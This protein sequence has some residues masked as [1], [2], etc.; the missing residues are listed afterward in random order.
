[1]IHKIEV[2][3]SDNSTPETYEVGVDNV[4]SIAVR[5]FPTGSIIDIFKEREEGVQ[6]V[7]CK[8][9]LEVTY[10]KIAP[11]KPVAVEPPKETAPVVPP[12]EG[13]K[14]L[15]MEEVEV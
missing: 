14:E 13:N 15:P 8:A 1:M 10:E 6:Y 5:L 7:G 3:V 11:K 2:Y 4:K 12:V 9:R